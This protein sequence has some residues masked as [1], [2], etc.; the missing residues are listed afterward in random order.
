MTLVLLTWTYGSPVSSW[1]PQTHPSNSLCQLS[2]RLATANSNEP[3]QTQLLEVA[4][5]GR[6]DR[7][8]GATKLGEP[9]QMAGAALSLSNHS[10]GPQKGP[11]P[12]IQD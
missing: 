11:T 6:A 9:K 2:S 10:V 5:L 8:P 7:A 3:A 12:S 4:A 1:S